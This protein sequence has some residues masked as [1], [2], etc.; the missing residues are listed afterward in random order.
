M[1][2]AISAP[3]RV[4]PG[5]R[6]VGPGGA[7]TWFLWIACLACPLLAPHAIR[8]EDAEAPKSFQPGD[9]SIGDP[10]PLPFAPP[11]TRQADPPAAVPSSQ[12]VTPS[13]G[14]GV[15][16]PAGGWLG[17]SVAES[18]APGRWVIADV[19]AG[20]PA[21]AAGIRPGDEIRAIE[22]K[23]LESADDVSQAL[24]AISQGQAVRLTVARADQATDVVVT[25]EPRPSTVASKDWRGSPAAPE[26]PTAAPLPVPAP[27]SVVAPVTTAPTS[28]LATP[29]QP[30]TLQPRAPLPEPRT[31]S[32]AP[33]APFVAAPP[34]TTAGATGAPARGRTAL[35]VRTVPIDQGLQARFGLSDAQGAYVIGVVEDLP[36]S[37]AGIPPGSVI[38]AIDNR[39]VRSPQDLTRLVT[40]GPIDRPVSLQYVLPG[41]SAKRAD[42]ML[43]SLELPLEQALAGPA[44]MSA[45]DPPA[46]QPG[47]APR[48]AQRPPPQNAVETAALR[49]EIGWLRSRLER[50]E[51]RLERSVDRR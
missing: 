12:A 23:L 1:I 32:A 6:D 11:A 24:T 35:G 17:L 13:V 19:A 49:E 33:A 39:P 51:Q 43:Q 29:P 3:S 20:G 22:G 14:A 26:G 42:V 38:V 4:P 41:G 34:S 37:R 2:A 15:P 36:A 16:G 50:L 25:A 21:A 46:L 18:T 40:G 45:T 48:T 10:I 44:A 30:A 28:V 8:A 47:P 7:A 9:I 27:A 31:L 5:S